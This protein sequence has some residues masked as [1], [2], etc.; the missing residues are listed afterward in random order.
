MAQ[1][2][3]LHSSSLGERGATEGC[4]RQPHAG[5]WVAGR[6][7]VVGDGARPVFS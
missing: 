7:S 1:T 2:D 6:L 4:P 5:R 3:Q